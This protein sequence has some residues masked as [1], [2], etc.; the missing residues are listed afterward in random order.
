MAK[1]KW[2]IIGI[3]HYYRLS[4]K[5]EKET[6]QQLLA[7]DRIS[8]SQ[9]HGEIIGII[10]GRGS[11]KSTL[12][13]ILHG[14][15][16]PSEGFLS[17]RG[18]ISARL[19][20]P[21]HPIEH[22]SG[23][24]YVRQKLGKWG[25][26]KKNQTQLV[27]QIHQFS[28]LGPRFSKKVRC[29]SLSEKIQLEISII[30]HV[31]PSTI[32]MD[33]SLLTVKEDFYIKTFLFLKKLKELGSS[34]WIE[35]ENVKKIEEY[36]DKLLWLEFGQL[37]D[38]GDVTEVLTKYYDYYF[39]I[40]RLTANQQ[41][42]FWEQ[43]YD[44]Q[45]QDDEWDV[46][47]LT[48]KS[49]RIG[50][51]GKA[52]KSERHQLKEV[53]KIAKQSGELANILTRSQNNQLKPKRNYLVIVNCLLVA[54][55]G[56]TIFTLIV[57]KLGTTSKQILPNTKEDRQSVSSEQLSDRQDEMTEMTSDTLINSRKAT[58][59]I[60]TVKKG[61]SLSEIAESFGLTI[62]EL[63]NWNQLSTEA[64]YPNLILTLT[65]PV[66]DEKKEN[67]P[68]ADFTYQVKE[69]DSL[70]LIADY[71]GISLDELK[72]VNQLTTET[73]YSGIRLLL[74]AA[75]VPSNGSKVTQTEPSTSVENVNSAERQHVVVSGET[76]YGISNAYGVDV[77]S[78][79]KSNF[80]QSESLYLGQVLTIP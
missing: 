11:G 54:L 41:L 24:N 38:H 45:L 80:L 20:L 47:S 7:L 59:G 63:M 25:I 74:P 65:K 57:P 40:N 30:L 26:S 4:A 29:Y 46:E 43:G 77:M 6:N 66:S 15:E 1:Q 5:D 13:A 31:A 51:S 36:C 32:I 58:D 10:G 27:A 61:E 60:Y 72:K 70:A 62:E 19:K 64:I 73:I 34:I 67:V 71:Y 76:L 8:F 42:T 9:E 79:Q 53:G 3:S 39:Q 50:K 23:E 55:S 22:Q 49:P 2:K 35:T 37:K 18:E 21:N 16:T 75:A 69:G 17:G 78:I 44:G 28:E 33:D 68:I 56:L 14:E 12:S 52:F 48:T